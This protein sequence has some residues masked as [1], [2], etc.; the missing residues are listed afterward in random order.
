[1]IN[2]RRPTEG[3]VNNLSIDSKLLIFMSFKSVSLKFF[4]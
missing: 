1:M 3:I 2:L 4:F